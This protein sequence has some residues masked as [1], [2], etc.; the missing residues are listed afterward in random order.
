MNDWINVKD[1]VPPECCEVI[2]FAT[3][4]NGM[5]KEIMIGHLKN[6]EWSHCCLFYGSNILNDDVTVT[7]WMPLPNY[8]K[9]EG[10]L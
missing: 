9:I 10:K 7:H 5:S 6:N 8:P 4:N 1:L 2:Y 3:T